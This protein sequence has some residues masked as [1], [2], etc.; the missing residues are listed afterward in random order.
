MKCQAIQDDLELFALGDLAPERRAEIEAHLAECPD[1]RATVEAY[2]RLLGE[3]EQTSDTGE[4]RRGFEPSLRQA[5]AGEIRTQRRWR[6]ARRAMA[7]ASAA[8]A[9][10]LLSVT[11]SSLRS[12]QPAKPRID[13]PERW[14]YTTD[15]ESSASPSDGIVVQDGRV[16][17]LQREPSG[18]HVAAV[19]RDTGARR[20]RSTVHSIG[21]LAADGERVFGLA[22]ANPGTLDL[23]ALDA[24][25]G[26]MLWRCAQPKPR[27]GQS[28]C[29]PV[30]LGDGRVGWA[31]RGTI[32]MLDAATGAACWT[33][34]IADEGMLSA[35]VIDGPRLY[36]ASQQALHCLDPQSGVTV[37]RQRF[38]SVVASRQRPMLA[39]DSERAYVARP[40]LAGRS[41]LLCLDLRSR[42]WLWERKLASVRSLLA[43]AGGVYLRG[44]EVLA[45]DGRTGKPMW[46]CAAGGCSPLTA[47]DGLIHFVDTNRYGRLIAVEQR[48]GERAWEIAGLRSCCA[49]A[50]RGNTGYVKTQDG[51]LHAIALPPKRQS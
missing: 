21:Y 42:Q 41:P 2:R 29:R 39:V 51:D 17:A 37:W 33:R 20:W 9:L 6:Y 13:A 28:P 40:R 14:R 35:G 27:R 11:W 4:P 43:A 48:T 32:L 46:A 7:A 1:C 24:R 26:A 5:V 16:Y 34:T 44:P 15:W 47:C 30:A 31:N 18:A 22:Q 10:V 8:A 36:V 25:S 49:F 12:Q 19:D 23:V 38:A 45:L 3:I 50:K